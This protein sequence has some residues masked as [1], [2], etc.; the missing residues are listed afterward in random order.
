[1]DNA[2]WH[3]AWDGSRWS[4]WSSL[5]GYLTSA[6]GA[7]SSA[8]GR[9]DVFLRGG[10]NALWHKAWDGSRWSGWSSLGGYLTSGPDAASPAAGMLD[11]FV[12]GGDN[13]LWQRSWEGSRW[14]PWTSH[15]GYLTS[16]PA[17]VST[18]LGRRDV[19]VKGGDNALWHKWL[20]DQAEANPLASRPLW[21]DR[22][23]AASRQAAEW[24]A[25]RP[26]DAALMDRIATR[27][28]SSWF[29]DWH[30]DVRAAVD[31]KVSQA[32]AAGQLPVLVAY[33]VPHRDCGGYSGGG[34]TE[35]SYRA[36]IRSFAAGIGNRPAAVIVEPDA[37]AQLD[38]LDA[39]TQQRRLD[40]LREAVGVLGDLPATAVYLDAGHSAWKPAGVM[41][42]RLRAA[43]VARARGFSL[44]VSNFMPT[45][46]EVSYGKAISDLL[47]GRHFVVD[48]SRNG[49][50]SNGEWCNPAGRALGTPPTAATGVARLDALLWVK[51][52]GESDGACNGGPAAGQWWAEYALGLASRAG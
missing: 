1:G 49:R 19:V 9:L 11:V 15:G 5:G 34:V 35:D 12:R 45:S 41:A 39:A 20:P 7:V 4:G 42:E 30:A 3:K 44:N 48:T 36:W 26:G 31:A 33:A 17:A 14:L 40:L 24:R 6:P 13:A 52:P 2:L 50:G 46:G 25:G 47:A 18:G 43:G 51:F 16:D 27:P 22:N 28:T 23:T 29:G 10:D 8:S 32:S 21:V 38:C 37:L